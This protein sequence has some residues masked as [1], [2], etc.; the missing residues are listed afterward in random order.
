[1]VSIKIPNTNLILKE[2]MKLVNRKAKVK[3]VWKIIKIENDPNQ[4]IIK[5]K[6]LFKNDI[7]KMIER[8]MMVG[9]HNLKNWEIQEDL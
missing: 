9:E 4:I 6:Y 8:K 7:K 1:M 2:G 3:S 5:N